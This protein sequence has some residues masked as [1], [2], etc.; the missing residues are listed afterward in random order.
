MF[1]GA[2]L[3]YPEH[4][5]L[6]LTAA[7][8]FGRG[9]IRSPEE[10]RFLID[11]VYGANAEELV[12]QALRED[13]IRGAGRNSADSGIAKSGTL[14]LPEGYARTGG[15]WDDDIRIPT[16]LGKPTSTL[17]LAALKDGALVP[18]AR[19]RG[20][21]AESPEWIAWRLSEVEVLSH[22]IDGE[23][24][25]QR[26]SAALIEAAKAAW[27]RYDRGKLLVILQESTPGVWT[28]S[29]E[30]GGVPQAISY[31]PAIGLRLL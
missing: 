26:F 29:A 24:A 16:R 28:G 19:Y 7:T 22:R 12:P 18:W 4:A 14:K 21:A 8:L 11:S 30:R 20:H 2:A 23:A 9:A 15:R 31:S 25:A 13:F 27:T 6:W 17:R 1:P 5:R 10:M 3:V